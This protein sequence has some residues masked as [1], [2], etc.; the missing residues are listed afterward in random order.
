MFLFL[1]LRH[2]VLF[3]DKAT[4]LRMIFPENNKGQIGMRRIQ[5][6]EDKSED[7]P[8]IILITFC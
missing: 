4:F 2:N 7:L 8:N 1:L 5:V 6:S 3:S